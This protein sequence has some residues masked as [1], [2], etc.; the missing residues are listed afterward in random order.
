MARETKV[1]QFFLRYIGSLLHDYRKY[2][3]FDTNNDA[4]FDSATFLE[5]RMDARPF[6]SR[7]IQTQV[8][9]WSLTQFLGAV[10]KF[11]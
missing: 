10:L 6:L 8:W 3:R 5:Q 7:F 4:H 2:L 1:R 11:S 9:V